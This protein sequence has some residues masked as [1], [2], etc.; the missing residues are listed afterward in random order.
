MAI[1]IQLL[2]NK[3]QR[4]LISLYHYQSL[5]FSFFFIEVLKK[6]YLCRIILYKINLIINNKRRKNLVL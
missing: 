6:L 4:M 5:N 2:I 1:K 3:S